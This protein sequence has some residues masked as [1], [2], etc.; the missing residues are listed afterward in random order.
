M[1]LR[2]AAALP[3]ASPAAGADHDAAAVAAD[4]TT[5]PG[6]AT[7]DAGPDGRSTQ[8]APPPA[9]I[10]R[11][12]SMELPDV[13][14]SSSPAPGLASPPATLASL[15]ATARAHLKDSVESSS[16]EED[17]VPAAA[18]AAA[19]PPAEIPTAT[20][21]NSPAAV[22]AS[23]DAQQ[24]GE[25]A[26]TAATPPGGGP[27]GRAPTGDKSTKSTPWQV[28]PLCVKAQSDQVSSIGQKM[29]QQYADVKRTS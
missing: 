15:Q 29:R 6:V 8:A 25:G 26:L 21:R 2:R 14:P 28:R 22:A 7:V 24:A 3:V 18:P 12:K 20:T 27:A 16:S 4:M 1:A 9:T 11:L 10:Q 23:I 5:S 19:Y 13:V 17:S